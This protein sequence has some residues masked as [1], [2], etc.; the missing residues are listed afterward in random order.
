MAKSFL[1]TVKKMTMDQYEKSSMDKKMDKK[2]GYKE[3]SKED[4]AMDRKQ[5]AK[6][7]A[8]RSKA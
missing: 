1:K 2:M 5:L 3:G 6:I 7:N 4:M 8:K